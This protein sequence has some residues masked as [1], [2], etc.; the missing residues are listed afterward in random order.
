MTCVY[1]NAGHINSNKLLNIILIGKSLFWISNCNNILPIIEITKL[2]LIL[3]TPYETIL[4][5]NFVTLSKSTKVLRVN[6]INSIPYKCCQTA[7]YHSF[8]Q[9]FHCK[10]SNLDLI[11]YIILQCSHNSW[12][13][14]NTQNTDKIKYMLI[15]FMSLIGSEFENLMEFE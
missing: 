1:V 15:G 14:W 12:F 2:K 8:Q 5:R 11:R 7:L 13:S 3:W 9:Q 10:I 4:L 6:A